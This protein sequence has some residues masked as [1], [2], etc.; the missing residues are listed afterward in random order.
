[1]RKKNTLYDY[2]KK[3]LSVN[4]AD[5]YHYTI[6]HFLKTNQKAKK[7]KYQ[8]LV[9][10]MELVIQRYPNTQSQIRILSSFK[11]YYNYLVYTDQRPD[12]P[13]QTLTI[14]K[15][16]DNTIQL[17]DLFTTEELQLLLERENRYKYLEVRNKTLISFLIYQGLTCDEVVRLTI[18]DINLDEGTVCIKASSKVN[19]R[20][21]EL[22]IKQLR[23]LEDYTNNV[24]PKLLRVKTEKLLLNKQGQPIIVS[25]VNSIIEPMK[26]YF[27]ER[28]LNPRTIRM[29]VISNWL[30]ERKLPLETVQE[31]AGHKW[32]STTQKYI[33]TDS[34][35]QVELINK[36]FPI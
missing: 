25:T 8:D 22:T 2:L 35:R 9:D 1:M 30:N 14:R 29:S 5:N 15:G 26:S 23:L 27:P 4:T 31:L 20:T 11:R 3:S 7:Y 24:R 12:H 16:G 32:P 33:R 36:Y 6:N 17:Q 21:L 34:Q 19:S 28:N 18:N 10:Y 13:C